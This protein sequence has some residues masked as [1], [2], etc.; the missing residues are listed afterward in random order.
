M[1]GITTMLPIT[2]P[3]ATHGIDP[4]ILFIVA[5]LYFLSTNCY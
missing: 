5:V 4:N 1:I 2:C 3:I